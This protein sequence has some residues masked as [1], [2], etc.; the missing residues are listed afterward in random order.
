[1]SPNDRL[2]A[3]S[4]RRIRKRSRHPGSRR[5]LRPLEE[6]ERRT[7][8]NGGVLVAPN[9]KSVSYFDPDG[10]LVTIAI[11][12]GTFNPNGTDFVG[13]VAGIGLQ[14][15]EIDLTFPGFEGA[16][17]TVS[18]VRGG[19]GDGMTTIGYVNASG[20]NLG[21]VSIKGDLGRID[22]GSNAPGTTA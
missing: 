14:I 18:V 7:L 8:L 3:P 19:T 17:L 22:A 20:R 15:Q 1:M 12:A 9:L 21:N 13:V 10:D 5:Y 4:P 11:S 2:S 16:N 6:L